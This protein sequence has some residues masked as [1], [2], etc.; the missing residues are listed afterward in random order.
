[1]ISLLPQTLVEDLYR[2]RDL[3]FESHS[4]DEAANRHKLVA[5]KM[6]VAVQELD[7]VAGK[8]RPVVVTFLFA[9]ILVFRNPPV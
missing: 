4:L 7:R 2:F 3:F 6:E 9:S 8:S 1:M 5:E